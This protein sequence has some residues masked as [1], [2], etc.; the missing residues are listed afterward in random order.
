MII[1]S[2]GLR[3]EM[4]YF[5]GGGKGGYRLKVPGSR[6]GK[7]FLIF[8]FVHGTTLKR[9]GNGF[10]TTLERR[11]TGFETYMKRSGSVINVSLC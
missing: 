7:R 3:Y 2:T 10:E 1:Q 5:S 9:S 4:N 6:F 8:L 11:G